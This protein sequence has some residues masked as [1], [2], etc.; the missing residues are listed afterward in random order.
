MRG[1]VRCERCDWS[2]IYSAV[3]IARIPTYCPAC[4]RRVIR[5]RNPSS[6]SP[7]IAHWRSVADALGAD[8][9][10]RRERPPG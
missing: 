3:A 8:L 4:G 1:Y 10:A 2:R 7:V 6:H 5:E 9:D